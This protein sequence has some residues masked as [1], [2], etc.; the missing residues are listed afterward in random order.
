MTRILAIDPGASGGIAYH[1]GEATTLYP[2][3]ET[4]GDKRDLL[5]ELTLSGTPG[6]IYAYME[7]VG[8]YLAGAKMP[9]SR[10]F[11]FGEGYGFIKGVLMTQCIPL[12]LVTPQKW[13][14]ALS[15]A[16]KDKAE[17]KRRLKA[18]AQQLYPM[19]DGITLK[20]CDALLILHYALQQH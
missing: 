16:E 3:P 17:R 11:S 14:K 7:Q 4:E 15:I 12:E 20:T 18:K 1:D 9:G 5:S 8:G 19:V 2:M 13:Q 6:K 10:M